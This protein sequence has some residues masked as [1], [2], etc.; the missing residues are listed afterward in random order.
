MLKPVSSRLRRRERSS[1]RKG[2]AANSR[3]PS[4]SLLPQWNPTLV[5]SATGDAAPALAYLASAS[6]TVP[7][8]SNTRVQ[9]PLSLETK[10]CQQKQ[11]AASAKIP[12]TGRKTYRIHM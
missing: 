11:L 3:G 2:N 10:V 12:Y 7:L 5:A 8:I 1:A 4:L 6:A 9:T